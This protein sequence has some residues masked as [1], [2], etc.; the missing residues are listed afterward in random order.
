MDL[1]STDRAI[2]VP[3]PAKPRGDR[4]APQVHAGDG[5]HGHAEHDESQGLV[6]QGLLDPARALGAEGILSTERMGGRGQ[7]FVRRAFNFGQRQYHAALGHAAR[8]VPDGLIGGLCGITARF[9]FTSEQILLAYA[10]G[11]FPMEKRGQLVWECPDPRCVLPLAEL[12]LPSRIRTYLR[13]GLFDLCFDGDPAG[14]LAACGDRPGTWLT[15]RVQE[16]YLELFQLGA[17]H[18][19]EA[20][21]GERLVGG[22]FGIALGTV[23][24]VESMFS[25]EDHASKLAFAHLCVHA[26]ERGYTLIDC[27]YQ[28]EHFERFGAIEIPRDDYRKRLALGLIA[29]PSFVARRVSDDEPSSVRASP[30]VRKGLRPQREARQHSPGAGKK[31]G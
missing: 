4:P 20:W 11:L 28:A 13:K 15:R 25:R 12:H 5:G 6:K 14:V 7:E 22:A 16:A 19:V 24:T 9:P 18:T 10:Q 27:Q 1:L 17:M 26:K 31:P 23:F 21:Q 2:P 8:L 3:V 29:P 30:S